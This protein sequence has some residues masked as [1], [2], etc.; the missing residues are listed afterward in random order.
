MISNGMVYLLKKL[1]YMKEHKEGI[2]KAF[3]NCDKFIDEFEKC[4]NKSKKH[5][6]EE[7]ITNYLKY[8]SD[9]DDILEELKTIQS[10]VKTTGDVF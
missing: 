3:T 10:N 5:S 2:L 6:N 8:Y 1:A 9:G 7:G 4:I